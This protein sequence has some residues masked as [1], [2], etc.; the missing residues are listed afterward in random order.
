MATRKK[1]KQPIS[2]ARGIEPAREEPTTTR[3]SRGRG[4]PRSET[5]RQAILR[6]AYQ[7]L[8]EHGL[9]AATVD[10]IARKAG[11]SKATVYRWWSCKESVIM[12]GYLEAVQGRLPFAT[13]GPLANVVRQQMKATVDFFHSAD[14]RLLT[15]L[16]TAAQEDKALAVAFRERFLLPRREAAKK[17]LRQAIASGAWT[18]GPAAEVYSRRDGHAQPATDGDELED[19]L[20]VVVDMLYAPLY[21]RLLVG[22]GALDDDF[23]DALV[24]HVFANC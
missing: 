10:A 3:D 6:A 2:K 5:S 7:V 24:G 23:I 9:R 11:V 1:T 14:G 20:N 22:H 18:P 15:Q 12:D 13:E 17:V 4:R 16:V 8:Q 21:Y 19:A